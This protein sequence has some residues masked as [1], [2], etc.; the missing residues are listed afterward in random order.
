VLEVQVLDASLVPHPV[1]IYLRHESVRTWRGY[2]MVEGRAAKDFGVFALTVD[3]HGWLA[4]V[5]GLGELRFPL[6]G[7]RLG[8]A[9]AFDFGL[10]GGG[11]G[12]VVSWCHEHPHAVAGADG[13][14]AP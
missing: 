4:R 12:Q 14:R 7:G 1:S 10:Q 9:I 2:V 8:P 6:P 5:D 13:I 11:H 3:D